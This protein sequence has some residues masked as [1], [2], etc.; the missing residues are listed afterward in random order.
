MAQ[1]QMQLDA[2]SRLARAERWTMAVDTGLAA[3][4]AANERGV[5]VSVMVDRLLAIAAELVISLLRRPRQP[6]PALL[7]NLCRL[8]AWLDAVDDVTPSQSRRLALLRAIATL[9]PDLI[10]EAVRVIKNRPESSTPLV[11]EWIEAAEAVLRMLGSQWMLRSLPLD[12]LPP[13]LAVVRTINGGDGVTYWPGTNPATG[14]PVVVFCTNSVIEHT[15]DGTRD[16]LEEHL[17]AAGLPDSFDPSGR[18]RVVDGWTITVEEGV[19]VL[20]DAA[21]IAWLTTSDPLEPLFLDAVA[22]S[23]FAHVIYADLADTDPADLPC[24][25]PSGFVRIVHP[26]QAPGSKARMWLS[27]VRKW[28]GGRSAGS[29]AAPRP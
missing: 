26:N 5:L 3:A 8:V 11:A 7:Y 10:D 19:L 13:G 14:M 21:G 16:P 12:D 17:V 22:N 4:N 9:A 6:P 23:S 25:R 29:R 24:T 1:M 27:R 15:A 18:P 28:F 2:A 20:R